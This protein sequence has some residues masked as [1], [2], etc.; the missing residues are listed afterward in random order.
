MDA[1]RS[2]ASLR[3]GALLVLDGGETR[4]LRPRE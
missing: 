3:V 1:I 4:R 2:M